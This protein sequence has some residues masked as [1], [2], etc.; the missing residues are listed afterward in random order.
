M[1][2]LVISDLH[3]GLRSGRD[4]LTAPAVI[5]ALVAELRET[6][7]LVLLGDVV[8]LR[9]GPVREALGLAAPVLAEIGAALG[10]GTEVFVVP[11]NHDHHLLDSWCARRAAA[12]APP[13]LGTESAVDWREGDP[14]AQVASALA[15]GGATVRAA[16]PG[17]WLA[18]RVWATHGHYLDRHTTIPTFERLGAG[19]MAKLVDRFREASVAPAEEYETVLSPIYAW[20][21]ATAQNGTP[22]RGGSSEGASAKVW[23][24]L[25]QGVRRGGWR[26]WGLKIVFPLMVGTVNRAGLGPVRSDIDGQAL[27]RA[28]LA[29]IGQVLERLEIDADHVIFGHTH[30]AGPLPGDDQGEW[31]AAGGMRLLNTGCWVHERQ[32]LGRDPAASPYRVGFAARIRDDRPPELVN[33][34]D[35]SS[36]ARGEA[37]GVADHA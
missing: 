12:Q 22:A 26:R 33:L 17:V 34:L 2:T 32:F 14:L 5:E 4:R 27:R 29:S 8:E 13:P 19:A 7:R 10:P 18:P 20:L 23:Q 25:R 9:H 16:Y 37:D 15:T 35:G 1:R 24:Q 21:H 31:R 6:D 3:L 30:R 36:E 28:P 11:G